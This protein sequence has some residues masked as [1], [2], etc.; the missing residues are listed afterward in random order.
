MALEVALFAEGTFVDEY[1]AA[2]TSRFGRRRKL[3]GAGAA[4]LYSHGDVWA[5]RG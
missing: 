3:T 4:A 1:L 5:R 2:G